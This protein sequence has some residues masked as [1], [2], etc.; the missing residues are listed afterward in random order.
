MREIKFKGLD[1]NDGKVK[2]V[3]KIDFTNKLV[4]FKKEDGWVDFNNTELMQY[5]GFNDKNS[6]E[7]FEGY[8][9]KIDGADVEENDSF[10]VKMD[11]FGR[12]VLARP[13]MTFPFANVKQ[14]EIEVIGNIYENPELLH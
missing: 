3:E 9:C 7:I 13:Y 8:I 4:L 2:E 14:N 6:M 5:T 1:R 10:I 12:Y 11:E